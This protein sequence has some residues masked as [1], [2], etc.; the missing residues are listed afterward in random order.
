MKQWQP[1][2]I[3]AMTR[4]VPED[5]VLIRPPR[6]IDEGCYITYR[7]KDLLQYEKMKWEQPELS[8]IIRS[9]SDENLLAAGLNAFDM[10]CR[11][12]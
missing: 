6:T 12:G 9:K 10:R 11:I 8:V 2:E 1:P 4:S 7:E 3:I 5:S